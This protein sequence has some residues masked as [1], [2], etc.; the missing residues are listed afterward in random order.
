MKYRVMHHL[1]YAQV[2]KMEI[3]SLHSCHFVGMQISYFN[4]FLY[5]SK[6]H[7]NINRVQL[8]FFRII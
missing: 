8:H 6:C 1:Q 5:E 2:N 7:P 4:A 3:V